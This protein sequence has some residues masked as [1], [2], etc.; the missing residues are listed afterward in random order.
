MTS[1]LPMAGNAPKVANRADTA[2]RATFLQMYASHS[3]RSALYGQVDPKSTLANA[4][5]NP[6][7]IME[8]IN[9]ISYGECSADAK[10]LWQLVSLPFLK[11]RILVTAAEELRANG[12]RPSFGYGGPPPTSLGRSRCSSL[13]P[14]TFR[15]P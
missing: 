7:K 1:F 13:W 8:S 15:M 6:Q 9:V 10:L 3:C 11:A 4:V 12:R 2:T 5:A 14:H